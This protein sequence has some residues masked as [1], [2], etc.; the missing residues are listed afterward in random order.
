[1]KK[2][3]AMILAITVL[4]LGMIMAD[5]LTSQVRAMFALPHYDFYIN[6]TL[7]GNTNNTPYGDGTPGNSGPMMNYDYNTG[8]LYIYGPIT[9][10]N[11]QITIPAFSFF[12]KWDPYL[13]YSL[14]FHNENNAAQ[15]INSLVLTGDIY[16]PTISNTVS[17]FAKGSVSSVGQ[18]S[19]LGTYDTSTGLWSWTPAGVDVTLG[20]IKLPQAGPNGNWTGAR[21]ELTN[22]V[23]PVGDSTLQGEFRV[24]PVPVPGAL[25]L[26]GSGLAAVVDLRKRLT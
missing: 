8:V 7:I 4:C 9:P 18:A 17:A 12:L 10:P 1:M 24:N 11:I 2:S 26:L 25:W 6:G 15:T 3:L 23:I 14:S 13:N 5:G 20:G 22:L 19:S 21:I 16:L